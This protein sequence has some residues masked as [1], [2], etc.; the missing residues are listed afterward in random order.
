MPAAGN[1]N[2]SGV[3]NYAKSCRREDFYA[4]CHIEAAKSV[5]KE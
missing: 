4:L 1:R 5:A 2:N 3:E